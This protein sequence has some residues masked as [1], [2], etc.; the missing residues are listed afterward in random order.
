MSLSLSPTVGVVAVER[1]HRHAQDVVLPI[2]L[3]HAKNHLLLIMLIMQ[4]CADKI[5]TI[6]SQKTTVNMRMKQKSNMYTARS[7][8]VSVVPELRVCSL[9]TYSVKLNQLGDR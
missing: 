7:L 1:C 4:T 2:L 6:P 5:H 8:F 9:L 3:C